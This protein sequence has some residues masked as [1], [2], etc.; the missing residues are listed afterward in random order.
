MNSLLTKTLR[1]GAAVALCAGLFG[2]PKE[3]AEAPPS[4]PQTKTETGGGDGKKIRIAVIPKGTAHSFWQSIKAGADAAGAEEGVEIVWQGPDKENDITSQVNLVQSQTNSGVQGV[5]LAATDATALVK[6][7]E[8]LAAKGIPVV[9]IDS[10]VNKDVTPAYIATDNVEGGR[11]G[12]ENLA[13]SI[14]EK[15]KVGLLFFL[16]G[17]V[18]NDEREK[19]FKEGLKKYP[20]IQ[21]VSELEANDPTQALNQTTNMMTANPDIVGVFAANEPNGVGAANYLRQNKKMGK[22]RLVAYDTSPEEIKALEEGAIDALIVQNP[23]KMGYEGVKTVLKAIRKQTIEKKF[24]DSG[25]VVVNK[26]NLNT[27]D[28]Q[29]LLNPTK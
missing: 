8:E 4:T 24:I 15:G 11:L 14:G 19:G 9:T 13:K 29:K 3:Q 21:L 28:I 17:S 7:I 2:C 18:S 26:A 6:P 20:N 27:P 10:G 16:R 23:F 12:A 5:I 25:V 1:I 22:V